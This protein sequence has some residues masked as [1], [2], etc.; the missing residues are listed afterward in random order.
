MS[1]Q[2]CLVNNDPTSTTL[3][4]PDGVPL[5]SIETPPMPH[6]LIDVHVPSPPRHRPT[7]ATTII[8]RLERYHMS[9][10]HVETEIGIIEYLGQPKGCHLQLSA[11][12]HSLDIPPHRTMLRNREMLED[13]RGESEEEAVDNS[14]EFT[15]PDSEER[16]KWHLF[17]HIPVMIS[18]SPGNSLVPIAR[19]RRAKLGIV[20]RSRRAFLEI[21]PAGLNVIDLIVVTFVAFMK[22]RVLIDN[23]E[24]SSTEVV[25]HPTQTSI[26]PAPSAFLSSSPSLTMYGGQHLPK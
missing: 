21:F 12:N 23:P 5:F 20:S 4:T 7:T 15:Y 9:T 13:I 16:Y 6:S 19:Y 11:V 3:V 17:A 18:E 10:G 2:L 22:Q 14:W 25:Q 24:D 1:M 8:K 26:L